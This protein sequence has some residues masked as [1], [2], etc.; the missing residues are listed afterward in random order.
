MNHVATRWHITGNPTASYSVKQFGQT[1]RTG[2]WAVR[3]CS[4]EYISKCLVLILHRQLGN[5]LLGIGIAK[6]D[7]PTYL[8]DFI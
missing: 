3:P 2:C 8:Q 1:L 7:S 5:Y 4:S 6:A